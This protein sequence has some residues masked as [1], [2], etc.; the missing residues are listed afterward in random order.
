MQQNNNNGP[1]RPVLVDKNHPK[2]SAP[3]GRQAPAGKQTVGQRQAMHH[4]SDQALS[5]ANSRGPSLAERA[6]K[7]RRELHEQERAA[8]HPHEQRQAPQSR[9]QQ[10]QKKK[11][12]QAQKKEPGFVDKIFVRANVVPG[13]SAPDYLVM[14][15]VAVLLAIGLIMVFSASS[16]RS[17]LE[18]G[19]AFSYFIRQCAAAVIGII[20]AFFVMML[21]PSIFRSLAPILLILVFALLVY[22][23]VRRGRIPRRNALGDDRRRAFPAVRNGEAAHGHLHRRFDQEWRLWI[24]ER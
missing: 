6:E 19:S 2:K 15:I 11:K 24:C 5:M 9:L 20:A 14:E 22:T 13:V 21:N 18:N 10:P 4:A 3:G 16:Y 7:H 12:Q 8:Q 17:L 1:K 23:L